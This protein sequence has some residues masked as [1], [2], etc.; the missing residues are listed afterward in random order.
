M[1]DP[2]YP[3][4]IL[5]DVQAPD[6]SLPRVKPDFVSDDDKGWGNTYVD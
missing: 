3:L 5:S 1:L 6:P 2:D 4:L